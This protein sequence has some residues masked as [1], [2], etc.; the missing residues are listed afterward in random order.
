MS[1]TFEGKSRYISMKQAFLV[2]LS[3]LLF[4]SCYTQSSSVNEDLF[5]KGIS[6]GINKNEKLEEASGLANSI[7]Q[8]DYFWTINDSGNG[9]DL[10][11]INKKANTKKV[12]KLFKIKNRDWEDIAIGPGPEKNIPYL[13]VGDIGD[14]IARHPYK[15]IYRLKEPALDQPEKITEFDTLVVKLEDG[16]R[17]S[18]TLMSDPS[19]K[20]LY[21]VSKRE[22][23]VRVYEIPFD[24][25]TLVAK[26]IAMLPLTSINGGSISADG[27]E[28]LLRNYNKIYYW[29]KKGDESLAE[30]FKTP[31]TELPYDRELQG[32]SIAWAQDGS[33]Y[34]TLGENAKGERSKLLFY[35]RKIGLKD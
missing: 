34:F 8:P 13:Y 1:E 12:F 4:T 28:V 15:Y 10:F 14:N 17:D 24:G 22:D 30:L 27:K 2:I 32:E 11:L 35:K 25:D 7:L 33:G 21:L 6:L 18:E 9:A 31:A 20:N 16:I 3:T 29:K 23:S 26:K 5:E 19:T